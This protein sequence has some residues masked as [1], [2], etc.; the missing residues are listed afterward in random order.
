MSRKQ[1]PL[2]A[3][4]AAE[5][6][7]PQAASADLGPDTAEAIEAAPMPKPAQVRD[8]AVSATPVGDAPAGEEA[9]P[10]AQA[11]PPAAHADLSY[12]VIAPLR[13]DGRRYA[14]GDLVT[15]APAQA[16]RLIGLRV[17]ADQ[18]VES[19]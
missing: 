6:A 13:H 11:S 10:V 15:L 1:I 12:R 8:P 19:A 17:V 14:V 18:P 2:K 16:A 4:S 7:A 3:A 5:Q 9:T